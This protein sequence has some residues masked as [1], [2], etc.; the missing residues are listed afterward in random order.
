MHKVLAMHASPDQA[1]VPSA[2]GALLARVMWAAALG[3]FLLGYTS[4]VISGVLGSIEVNLIDPLGLAETSRKTLAGFAVSSLFVGCVCGALLAGWIGRRFGRKA[5]L[6]VAALLFLVS[7]IGSALPEL[8]IGQI[9]TL[10]REALA[11][12]ILYRILC[13]LAVGIVSMLA[14]LLIAELATPER[15]GRLVTFY[16]LAAVLGFVS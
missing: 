5:G 1:A 13:G 2:S 6:L 11:A 16:Q 7:A 8:G 15:R 4:A 3:G 14:P 12:F 9:G 10:N